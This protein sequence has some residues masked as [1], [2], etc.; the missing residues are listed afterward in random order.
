MGLFW[1]NSTHRIMP[2]SSPASYIPTTDQ[3][4]AHWASA[5][6]AQGAAGPIVVLKTRNLDSLALLRRQLEEKRGEIEALRNDREA[7][8]AMLEARKAALLV[9]LNQ[10]NQKVKSDSPEPR[11]SA[12]LPAAFSVTD[13][14]GRVIPRLDEMQSLW[15]SY[16]ASEGLL[17]LMKGYSLTDFRQD[18][19]ALK[20]GYTAISTS[21]NALGIAR[22]ERTVLEDTI[23]PILKA[24]RQRI[25]ADFAPDSPLFTTLPRLTPLST[26]SRLPAPVAVEGA[27]NAATEQAELT[28][29]TSAEPQLDHYEVRAVAGPEWDGEDEEP[30]ARIPAGAP[31]RW[32]GPFALGAPGEAATFKVYVVLTS[33][34][35]SGSI[36]VTVFRP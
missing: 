12:L 9:R 24:Y 33:G 23:Q 29:E 10:F 30:I 11:W 36:P 28:W 27:W 21:D 8:R 13:G 17:T 26:T 18:L 15:T 2:I 35:E 32:T 4:L 6:A 34:H 16:N 22:A 19:A 20:L 3:F 14:Y 7:A 31:C 5:N 1:G 25:Q